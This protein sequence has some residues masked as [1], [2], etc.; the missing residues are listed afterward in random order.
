[1][2]YKTLTIILISSP[3]LI[4]ALPLLSIVGQPS[5]ILVHTR[6]PSIGDPIPKPEVDRLAPRFN[7]GDSSSG[8]S[9][10]YS[11]PATD[12]TSPA[13]PD[14]TTAPILDTTFT[15]IPDITSPTFPDTT[16]AP[17]LGTAFTTIPDITSPTFPDT[18]TAPILGTTVVSVP[19]ITTAPVLD[20]TFVPVPDITSS[21]TPINTIGSDSA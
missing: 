20:T 11:T 15:T 12:I 8:S 19:D 6:L 10:I 7:V 5:G 17:I 21:P 3:F 1:M 2:F 14:I 16:T 9:V 13:F 4:D 18:T